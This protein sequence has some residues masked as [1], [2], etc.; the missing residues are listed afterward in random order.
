L[1]R[2]RSLRL[3]LAI[4]LAASGG[5]ALLHSEAPV[6]TVCGKPII[7]RYVEEAGKAYHESCYAEHVAPR[8]GV[9]GKPILGERIQV[10]G[11]SYHESCYREF[12]LPR[13]AVCGK[14]IEGTY[15]VADGKNYHP[16]CRRSRALRCVVCG[17]PLEDSY[18]EDGWGNAFHARHGRE[19]LCPFCGRVMAPATTGGG[20]IST[21]NG[22]RICA[23][24]AGRAVSSREQIEAVLERVRLRLMDLFP[25]PPGSFS[26][27]LVDRTHL[28]ERLPPGQALGT[29]LGVTREALQRSGKEVRRRI[30]VFL[31]SGIPDWLLDGVA[32]HELVH[33]WQQ[34]RGLDSLPPEQA[35]GTAEYASYL[36]LREGGTQEGKVKI[37][38]MEKSADKVY[39]RGFRRAVR[40][41]QMDLSPG[42]LR[43]ILEKGEGWPSEP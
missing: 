34:Q 8:C 9:C 43:E 23:L 20:F 27:E 14:P 11:T 39:G 29:E 38:A 5:W 10:E 17:A 33:V 1:S 6:C 32:A 37:E 24:C 35:E 36:L 41:A 7:G 4:L 19:I 40:A 16:A 18:L 15:L 26:W 42:R 13:C 3:L 2:T 22:I 21:A 30:Q 25:V 28:L 31:L 12:R